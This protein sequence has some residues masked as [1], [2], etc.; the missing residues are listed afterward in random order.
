MSHKDGTQQ[1][2]YVPNP[3]GAAPEA[4]QHESV[5]PGSPL[6]VI[7]L[8]VE[9]VRKRFTSP[10]SLPW[11]YDPDIKK[12]QIA[13]ESAFNEDSAHR[14]KRPAIYIDHS[15]SVIGRT[16][17][18]D[19]AGQNLKTGLRGFF[20]LNTIPMLIECV[21]LKKGEAMLIG[22]LVQIYLH[23]S[24]DLIQ[25]KFK[26]H[27]LTPITLGRA[28]PYERDATQWV[29][30]ITFSVQVPVRWTNAP[31]APLIRQIIM[32]IQKSD[33]ADATEFFQNIAL[34]SG[35]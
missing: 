6:A 14:N 18:G 30:P 12:T 28:Q 21:A 20:G 13:I 5:R 19:V 7:G 24:S 15:E 1:P 11:K 35:K 9:L 25:A 34:Y 27:E 31:T 26:L 22:D 10:H 8:F 23:A 29:A 33:S 16:V 2:T 4:P 17:T 3:Q 32:D